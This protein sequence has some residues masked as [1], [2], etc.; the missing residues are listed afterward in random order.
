MREILKKTLNKYKINYNNDII[1]LFEKY[2]N[3]ILE[4]N[5]K[6]NLTSITEINEIIL[7]HFLDCVL[8]YQ[9]FKQNSKI[10]DVGSGAGFPA[11]PL[12]ILR[13]DLNITM[14]D[15][16]NKRVNFLNLV[17]K[18]LDLKNIVAMH[19][20]ADT[21]AH[22]FLYREK[23]DYG[24]AR[25]VAK[26]PTLCEYVIPFVKC[27]GYMVAY[28]S[29][30]LEDELSESKTAIS[31]LGGT[32]DHIENY[33]INEISADRN[34]VFIKKIIST[35]NKFPRDKNKPKSEPII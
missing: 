34:I 6:I 12:K 33:K 5:E 11:I 27:G 35:P 22:N 26:L 25:A 24:V 1:L 17:I 19:D 32:L 30:Q 8:P 16:L 13:P 14:V 4:W 23:F 20:R 2:L 3:L 29:L 10:I 31:L 21:L 7:K 18:E 28:K 9:S 15:S